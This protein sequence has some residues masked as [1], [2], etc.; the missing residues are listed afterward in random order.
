[1]TLNKDKSCFG[2]SV[3]TLGKIRSAL[4]RYPEIERVVLY[5]SR[6]K[7]NAEAGSDIDLT[8]IGDRF[9]E[10][11]LTCLEMDLDDLM[12]PYQIDLSRL[13]DIKNQDLVDHIERVGKVFL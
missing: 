2:L 4:K 8:I 9:T 12:L 10:R 13:Q 7:G 5:G 11:Q 1:M 3:A 6:A